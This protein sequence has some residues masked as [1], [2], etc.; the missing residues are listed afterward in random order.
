MD[1]L[2]CYINV[3]IYIYIYIYVNVVNVHIVNYFC[4]QIGIEKNSEKFCTAF[5][6]VFSY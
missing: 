6:N 1:F 3:Y 4:K 5:R 2:I